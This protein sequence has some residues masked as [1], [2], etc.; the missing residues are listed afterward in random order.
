MKIPISWL[1]EYVDL[2]GISDA[3][4]S[5]ALTMSGTE[6]EIVKGVDFP[7]IVVGEV[8]EKEKH[9]NA[10]RL[11][12]T[13]VNVG[14]K[15]GGVLQI[16]CGAPNVEPGQKVPVALVGAVIGEFEIKEAE[17][18]GV[19]SQ[20]MICS[21][22]EL[23]I[24]DD[25]S[26]IMVLDARAEVGKPL[27]QELNIGGTVL[28]A[29]ITPN[30]SDC[31]SMVG[32]ARE[33]AA[34]LNRKLKNLKVE[35][36]EIKSGKTVKV[37]VAEKE[38][39]GRYIAKVIEGIKI[40]PS[41]KWMQD[42]LA[43]AGVRP[44]NNVVDVTNYVMMEWGQPMHAFDHAKVKGK[45]IVRRAEVGEK[46]VTLDNIE[47]KLT[48]NDLVI[49]DAGK[50]IGLAGVMGGLN[51]EVTEKTTTVVL[52]AAVFDRTMVR[53]T[54]QRLALR[55]EASN[56]FEKGIPLGLPELAIERA[57]KLL[58]EVTG[59]KA[60]EGV[61]VLSKWIWV[62]H[63]GLE[64]SRL[65]KFLGIEISA[66]EATKILKSLGFE[67]EKFDFKKEARRHVGK[68]YLWGASYKTHGDMAFDCSYLTDY[69][70]SLIGKFIGHTSLAQYELGEEVQTEDLKP[71]D[72]LFIRG[73]IDKS[74][75][76]HYFV[77]NEKG[78]HIRVDLAE[79]KEVGH[80]ALYIGNGRIIHGFE[81]TCDGNGKEKKLTS[82]KIVEEDL[83]VIVNRGDFLGARRFVD[84]PEDW[85]AVDVPW[86]RLDISIQ[87]DLF[88]EIGRIYGYENLPSTL[89][90]AQLP[91]F[92]SSPK[93]VLGGKIREV[94]T[95][96]GFDEVI[97]YS[98][99]SGKLLENVGAKLQDALK[100]ANPLS[101]ENEY[102]RTTLAPS[103][104]EDVRVN[105]DNFE[106][107]MAFEVAS[108][109]KKG[110]EE[111]PEEVPTLGV[112]VK[113]K[114]KDPA[115]N[116]YAAKGAIELLAQ[117]L[118]LGKL[119]VSPTEKSYLK[120]GQTA[121]V[122][123]GGQKVGYLGMVNDLTWHKFDLKGTVAL[124]EI[125]LAEVI[126]GYGKVKTYETISRF[127]TV[128]RDINLLFDKKVTAQDIEK[129]LGKVM[130]DYLK[131]SFILDIFEGKDL[132]ENFKSVT[133][134]MLFGSS[135][136]T[137]TEEEILASQ[138]KVSNIL[139]KTLG[140]KERV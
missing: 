14:K 71:G 61:D 38:L 42:R 113:L 75:K 128:T 95:G 96:A 20:G 91:T 87:E 66:E 1:A 70:Y 45:I 26:G 119:E 18:R 13:K 136:K 35:K 85:V 115:K 86:W 33:A 94:L 5:D 50:A 54:A 17:L 125:N 37:E 83:E 114:T 76:D 117:K 98:F 123:I 99:I 9:P 21:E 106:E 124:A 129:S 97:N 118:N 10:D 47:R 127:P 137:L 80:N 29:E 31:F 24:S 107:I 22:S 88:E 25:H 82:P 77:R 132:P 41:P 130:D 67:A 111:L 78:E 12:V 60:G 59:G 44:I 19:K 110:K 133:I 34:V 104:L 6:N 69:L 102:M 53:K 27:A 108:I 58:E 68:P 126:K 89:P 134:R 79:P 81:F 63:V 11:N 56:R 30:R 3:E 139:R 43:A 121:L 4:L 55:S 23:G 62:Q 122:E 90:S 52:E 49:A 74:V 120:N 135:E 100:V 72:I 48:K 103:L 7:N 105:Q 64:L 32:I 116:F 138:K 92:I 15:N 40:G 2:K 16:V 109:Y 131:K 140:G 46:L 57:A 36:P 65:K 51:S 73:K 112:V 39:C 101:P 8:L 84:D 28:E 93:N